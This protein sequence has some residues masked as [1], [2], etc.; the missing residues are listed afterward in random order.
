VEL[1]LRL[2]QGGQRVDAPQQGAG[3]GVV[4]VQHLHVHFHVGVKIAAQV[5]VEQ[6]QAAVGEF[7][8]EQAAGE[9]DLAVES[10]QG[11][12]LQLGVRTEVQ[13]VRDQVAGADAAVRFD[14]VADRGAAGRCIRHG[15]GSGS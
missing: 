8:G 1:G 11:G 13:L 5:A 7:V 9:A 3:L 6:F 12:F 4:D 14:A 2:G 15:K 10:L